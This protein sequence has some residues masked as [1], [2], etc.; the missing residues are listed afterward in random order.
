MPVGAARLDQA[1][2]LFEE[3]TLWV[4]QHCAFASTRYAL[5]RRATDDKVDL[6]HH[7]LDTI[8]TNEVVLRWVFNH[9]HV[10]HLPDIAELGGV[11]EVGLGDGNG[12]GS[13]S[14]AKYFTCL[15]G[16]PSWRMAS[17]PQDLPHQHSDSTTK[18]RAVSFAP[19]PLPPP[20]PPL[21]PA[22][23]LPPEPPPHQHH[24]QH[25]CHHQQSHPT[26]RTAGRWARRRCRHPPPH[27]Y[28]RTH[29]HTQEAES[30]HQQACTH[31]H[32]HT[33]HTHTHTHI[34]YQQKT[35]KQRSG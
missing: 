13:I 9:F 1:F 10:P 32:T 18:V 35:T 3:H 20:A 26:C 5:A 16:T 25:H 28:V 19:P 27:L 6:P 15:A 2:V 14:L 7:V 31:T 29:K 24:H 30:Q 34:T 8:S 4:F 11:G 22:L 33:P 17:R 21:P 12:V 23:P